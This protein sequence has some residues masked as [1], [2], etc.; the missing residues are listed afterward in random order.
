MPGG[1]LLALN[2][3]PLAIYDFSGQ[4]QKKLILRVDHWW[5]ICFQMLPEI[6]L[7]TP[8]SLVIWTCF[9]LAAV[10]PGFCFCASEKGELVLLCISE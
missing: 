4:H 2:E 9:G 10:S 6:L 3:Q 1:W 5:C 7:P 8:Q